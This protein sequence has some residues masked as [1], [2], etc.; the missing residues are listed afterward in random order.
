MVVK[1][2]HKKNVSRNAWNMFLA[3][4]SRLTDRKTDWQTDRYMW[5]MTVDLIMQTTLNAKGHVFWRIIHFVF[6]WKITVLY[7]NFKYHPSN[8]SY[9]KTDILCC[10]FQRQQKYGSFYKINELSLIIF[11]CFMYTYQS[12]DLKVTND[13]FYES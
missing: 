11:K 3:Y 2:W 13:W 7:S 9:L 5:S 10:L 1:W 8:G 6:F 4:T 12:Y